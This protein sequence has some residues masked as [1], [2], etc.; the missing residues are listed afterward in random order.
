M[1][2][3]VELR[4]YKGKEIL[5]KADGTVANENQKVT[6]NYDVFEFEK[7]IKNLSAQGYFQIELTNLYTN[8]ESVEK[9]GEKTKAEIN[10]QI[11]ALFKTKA[12]EKLTDD[13]KRIKDLEE[14]L[15]QVLA[16]QSKET[17]T[18]K[19]ATTEEPKE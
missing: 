3:I 15:A 6:L 7:N 4:V 9:F 12:E 2:N 19:T 1:A 8:D 17:K 16:N 10:E 13:Q 11:Q 14:K 18:K 5:R